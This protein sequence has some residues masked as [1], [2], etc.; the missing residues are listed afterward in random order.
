MVEVV[1]PGAL[2]LR[3]A[4]VVAEPVAEGLVGAAVVEGALLFEEEPQALTTRAATPAE[5]TNLRKPVMGRSAL[6]LHTVNLTD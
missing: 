2:A 5:A 4:S 6:L 1:I 3:A